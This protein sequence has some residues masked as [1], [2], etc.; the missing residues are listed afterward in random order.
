MSPKV[1]VALDELKKLLRLENRVTKQTARVHNVVVTLS[2]DEL[3]EYVRESEK[4]FEEMHKQ[5]LS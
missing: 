4:M 2:D 3:S 1:E 5:E